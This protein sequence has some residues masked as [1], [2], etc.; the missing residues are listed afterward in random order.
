MT[1]RP[2]AAAAVFTLLFVAHVLACDP[3]PG[4][5]VEGA[6]R[7]AGLGR[8]GNIDAGVL[9]NPC[10]N[11]EDCAV[12]LVCGQSCNDWC[13]QSVFPNPCCWRGCVARNAPWSCEAAGGVKLSVGD[14]PDG[15]VLPAVPADWVT[16]PKVFR[17][18]LPSSV[19]EESLLSSSRIMCEAY[20][21]CAW[22]LS[23][24][25]G[26]TPNAGTCESP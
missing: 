3:R 17:C 6:E 19:C 16:T 15:F 5:A 12:P 25:I 21:G 13:D 18:C 10:N 24:A 26:P 11:D 20:R 22:I 1:E 2:A 23:G 7:A 4:L 14:C 9:D 8:P